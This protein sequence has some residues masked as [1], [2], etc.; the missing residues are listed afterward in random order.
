VFVTS[1][2]RFEAERLIHGIGSEQVLGVAVRKD[3]FDA[4][5]ARA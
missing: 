5:A 3:C 2:G 4:A 1:S